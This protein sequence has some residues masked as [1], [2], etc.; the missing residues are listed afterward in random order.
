MSTYVFIAFLTVATIGL[1]NSA[2]A[3]L[4]FT[5][6]CMFKS[7]K[8]IPVMIGSMI[9]LRK[10]YSLLNILAV[11]LM[12]I[13]LIFFTLADSNLYPDFETY[14]VVL[15][16]SALIADAVIGN[17]QEKAMKKYKSSNTEMILYSYS[18]GFFYILLWELFATNN[19]LTAIHFCNQFPNETY[20]YIFIYSFFGYFGLNVVL[21]LVKQFGALVTV[22]V[23]SFRKAI[24]I[25]LS[26]ILFSK[27]F[28]FQYVWSGI[29]VLIGI[30][31]N[32][33][34]K[35]KT[36]WDIFFKTKYIKFRIMLFKRS[37]KQNSKIK[38]FV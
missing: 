31:L 3:H 10:K 9:I 38:H 17:I 1:S 27:P 30:Y 36:S 16:M 24:T 8:L 34:S 28:T 37:I 15:V 13:G 25:F 11:I 20:G 14:G 22:T 5:T 29:L 6:F 21:T 2:V 4:N 19:L 23:T 32:L 12:T 26:F 7:S 33:Y 35:N 18:I